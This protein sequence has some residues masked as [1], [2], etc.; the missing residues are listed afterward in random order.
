M[1]ILRSVAR[2][3]PPWLGILK[4]M[5]FN[6]EASLATKRLYC[7]DLSNQSIHPEAF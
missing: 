5:H 7:D 2:P 1:S 4:K 6:S 3:V